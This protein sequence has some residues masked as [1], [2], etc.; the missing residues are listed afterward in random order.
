MAAT[1][2]GIHHR[3]YRL[4]LRLRAT[5]AEYLRLVTEKIGGFLVELAAAEVRHDAA[6]VIVLRGG[7][8][9]QVGRQVDAVDA[10]R[11][12]EPH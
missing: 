5:R 12:G 2:T 1:A 7:D 8:G 9:D 10:V 6:R 11:H 4:E 3:S